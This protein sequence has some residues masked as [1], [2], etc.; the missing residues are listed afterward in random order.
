LIFKVL[1]FLEYLNT[2]LNCIQYF[3]ILDDLLKLKNMFLENDI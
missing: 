2:Y 1:E 3:I